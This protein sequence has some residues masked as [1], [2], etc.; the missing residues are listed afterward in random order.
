MNIADQLAAAVADAR[1]LAALDNLGRLTWRGFAEAHIA[2]DDAQ[3]L[4]T[5]IE[6]R[7][8]AIRSG[9]YASSQKQQKAA[10]ESRRPPR[11]PDRQRS[12]E[13]RR[14]IAASGALPPGIA[15]KLTLGE[16]AALAVVAREVQRRG[17]CDLPIDAIAALAGVSRRTVQ[18]AM[19]A[20]A[21]LGVIVVQE[22]RRRG[23][24][25][26]T[27]TVEIVDGS[28]R[29]WLRL[30]GGKGAKGCTPRNTKDF[31]GVNYLQNPPDSLAVPVRSGQALSSQEWMENTW[32]SD[33]EKQTIENH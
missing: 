1:T 13:R 18:N 2:E 9:G 19:K 20:A 5:A 3:A 29:T 12:L 23:A 14:R 22:R 8:V 24:P 4:G 25:S 26:L 10:S 30:A 15:C 7:R 11:S 32:L 33:T 31:R 6:A 28:W 27:N 17:R 16:T 21:Q